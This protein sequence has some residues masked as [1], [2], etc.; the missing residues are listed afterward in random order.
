MVKMSFHTPTL[1]SL[2]VRGVGDARRHAELLILLSLLAG[3]L[4]AAVFSPA[5]A[6]LNLVQDHMR[7]GG[8]GDQDAAFAALSRGMMT[9]ALSYMATLLITAL[10]IVPWARR[11]APK[12]QA[13][14][15]SATSL[16]MQRSGRILMHLLSGAGLS[17]LGF[18]AI[19]VVAT[20]IGEIV[21]ALNPIMVA[22]AFVVG[23]WLMLAVTVTA[24]L[25]VSA[26]ARDHRET[27]SSAWLR[28]RLFL[29]PMVGSYAVVLLCLGVVNVA[30]SVVVLSV[31][32]DRMVSFIGSALNFAFYFAMTAIQVAALYAVPD[33][34]DLLDTSDD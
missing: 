28:A 32:P 1:R 18:L 21:P 3:L 6:I 24:Y 29:Q 15:L 26:E 8:S 16:Y 19:I 17:F 34:R 31:I 4:S 27:I 7:P 12:S 30:V 25:A 5:Q 2:L 22:A 14:A 23:I 11:I 33:F 10:A 9:V 13:P 20:L